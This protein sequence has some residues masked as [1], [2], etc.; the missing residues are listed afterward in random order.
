MS[1]WSLKETVDAG[2][3]NSPFYVC[4]RGTAEAETVGASET[5]KTTGVQ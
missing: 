4:S 3:V 1:N 2:Q 5:V